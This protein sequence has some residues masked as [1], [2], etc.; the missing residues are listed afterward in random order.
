[1]E[2]GCKGLGVPARTEARRPGRRLWEESRDKMT[3]AG[4]GRPC[5]G[6]GGGGILTYSERRATGS[7]GPVVGS[8]ERAVREFCSFWVRL[9]V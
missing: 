6:G 2:K 8:E 1:M 3:E 4:P 7:I 5:G 9:W